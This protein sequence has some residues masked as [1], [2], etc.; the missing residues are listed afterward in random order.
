MTLVITCYFDKVIDQMLVILLMNFSFPDNYF[1][2][3][4]KYTKN[5]NKKISDDLSKALTLQ[6]NIR[7]NLF[8]EGKNYFKEINL[9]KFCD[10]IND[11]ENK[12]YD[13][14]NKFLE[15]EDDIRFTVTIAHTFKKHPELRRKII[16][17]LPD[18]LNIQKEKLLL[19]LNY[20]EENL[21]DAFRILGKI[22]FTNLNYYECKKILI[23]VQKK[24][25]WD[26]EII[27]LA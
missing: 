4:L 13:N 24:K 25:A 27:I 26:I 9:Q 22:D 3:L 6:F 7:D 10:F 1:N 23:I 15:I 16:E 17:N 20:D 2:Q 8:I 18:D 14:I 5:S 12:N 21:D 11:L 19:L